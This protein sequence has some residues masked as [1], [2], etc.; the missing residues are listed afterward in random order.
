MNR[1]LTM[2][3]NCAKKHCTIYSTGYRKVNSLTEHWHKRLYSFMY[4]ILDNTTRVQKSNTNLEFRKKEKLFLYD[5]AVLC[6]RSLSIWRKEFER[7]SWLWCLTH[8][9][10]VT[11]TITIVTWHKKRKLLSLPYSKYQDKNNILRYCNRW[12]SSM[13][14]NVYAN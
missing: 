14:Q 6:F 13:Y 1:K 10:R 3:T 7:F 4:S 9:C 11:G 8:H 2:H 5:W 12:I